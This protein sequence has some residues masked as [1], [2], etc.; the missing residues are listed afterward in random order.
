MAGRAPTGLPSTTMGESEAP[1][2]LT[3]VG[4]ALIVGAG[5]VQWGRYDLPAL[6]TP[7]AALLFAAVLFALGAA[8]KASERH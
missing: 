5:M 7:V 4:V 3:A 2:I 1:A 8:V 6:I